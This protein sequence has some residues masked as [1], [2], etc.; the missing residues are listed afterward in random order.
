MTRRKPPTIATFLLERFASPPGNDALA[1]DLA[2]T[3]AQ[4]RSRSWYW[5]QVLGA[6]ALSGVRELR[7]HPFLV[8]RTILIGWSVVWFTTILI[9]FPLSGAIRSWVFLD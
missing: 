9:G 2:E 1:G 8:L 5:L 3:Y 7:E 4:G 6:I